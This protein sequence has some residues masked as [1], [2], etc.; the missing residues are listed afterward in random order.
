MKNILFVFIITISLVAQAQDDPIFIRNYSLEKDDVTSISVPMKQNYV[1]VSV[2]ETLFLSDFSVTFG[3]Q[4]SNKFDVVAGIG[5]NYFG[6]LARYWS[7]EADFRTTYVPGNITSGKF[8]PAFMIGGRYFIKR[9]EH[10]LAAEGMYIGYE[11]KY[12]GNRWERTFDVGMRDE[13]RNITSHRFIWGVQQK[14]NDNLSIDVS[15][16]MTYNM[17]SVERFESFYSGENNQIFDKTAQTNLLRFYT[18]LHL[19]RRF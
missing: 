3:R 16:G 12:R 9:H 1:G 6:S 17:F 19:I 15:V 18:G 4:L 10:V 14:L 7:A 8:G 11:L 5:F 13:K 2:Y